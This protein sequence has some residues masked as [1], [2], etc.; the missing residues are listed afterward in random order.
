MRPTRPSSS[1]RERDQ[2]LAEESGAGSRPASR[3]ASASSS[4]TRARAERAQARMGRSVTLRPPTKRGS[5]PRRRISSVIW[6]PP[7]CTI[8]SRRP[9]PSAIASGSAARALPPSFEGDD[10]V[11]YSA[12]MRTYS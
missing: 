9:S 2:R 6:A 5:M 3:S 1:T 4:E 7:P 11:V 10:H 8:A 12:F